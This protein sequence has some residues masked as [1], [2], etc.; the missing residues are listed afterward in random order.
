MYPPLVGRV[1]ATGARRIGFNST[2]L[3]LSTTKP[4]YGCSRIQSVQVMVC[5]GYG[6]SRIRSRLGTDETRYGG[7][8]VRV[9]LSP[10]GSA[11]RPGS[12]TCVIMT[13]RQILPGLFPPISP[14]GVNGQFYCSLFNLLLFH[15]HGHFLLALSS[16]T[17][18]S[19]QS[20]LHTR[21]Y[22]SASLGEGV[23]AERT[24]RAWCLCRGWRS[25]A[26]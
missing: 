19:A 20:S 25:D 11:A 5:L 15:V 3:K 4:G 1:R 9:G 24:S 21:V 16:F 6:L 17:F 8:R 2:R 26:S 7:D 13:C 12:D 10:G 22:Q 18:V 14:Q 23:P